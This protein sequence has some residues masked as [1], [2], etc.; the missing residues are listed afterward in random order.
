M[1]RG[2]VSYN[3]LLS[4]ATAVLGRLGYPDEQ[5]RTTAKA[6]VEAEARG[7]PSHG[8]VR[9]S[10]YESRVKEGLVFPRAEPEVV[11]ETP[12]S[13][14]VD[15]RNGVGP[16]I[17]RFA[18]T[19][20]LEKATKI[21]AG[22]ASVRNSNHYGMAGLWAEMATEQACIGMSFC[23]T[24]A[25]SIPTFGRERILGTNPIC[26]A[27]PSSGKTHFL[28]DMA[29]TV[30]PRG[31]VEMYER[32]DLSIPHGWVVD[33]RGADTTDTR[34]FQELFNSGS[35]YGGHL[36]LGG[37]GED[38]GGHKGYGLALFVD[39]LC[40]GM[41]LGLWSRDIHSV[42]GAGMSAFFGAVR[43][44]LFGDPGEIA[45]HV[46]SILNGVRESDTAEGHD[47]IYIHGEKEMEARAR[48][49]AEGIT[50]DD[51]TWDLL[52]EYATRFGLQLPEADGR[53]W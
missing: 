7:L 6:L 9:L 18:M 48:S 47:R 5:A 46:E 50:L 45:A 11:H 2:N 44:D 20:V 8:V 16:H 42:R 21:G 22:F 14:V 51:A 52:N 25:S 27:V 17:A 28:L 12:L 33:E 24:G 40:A 30:V 43:T 34:R 23:N 31:K 35:P 13:L 29:T 1:K 38:L 19:R 4:F 15:G 37:A 49:L 26:L 41:S 36:L 53:G 10:P 3:A 39:L 32:R